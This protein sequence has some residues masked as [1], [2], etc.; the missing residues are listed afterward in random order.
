MHRLMNSWLH[1]QHIFC[2]RTQLIKPSVQIGMYDAE[3]VFEILNFEDELTLNDFFEVRKQN[4]LNT[5]KNLRLRLS[6]G[7]WQFLCWLRDLGPLKLA[8]VCFD[9]IDLHSSGQQ[10]A[11]VLWGCLLSVRRFWKRRGLGLARLQCF[12]SSSL[13][14]LVYRH[15]CCLTLE[16]MKQMIRLQ[17]KRKCLFLKLLVRLCVCVC[18]CVSEWEWVLFHLLLLSG[19]YN[20]YEFEPPPCGGTEITHKDAPQP[21]G[22]VWMSNQPVTETCAWQ[23]T[24]HSQRTTIHAPGGIRTR[25]PRKRSAVATRLW[26]LGHW[27]RRESSS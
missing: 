25:N 5:L 23:H 10:L 26:P 18:V 3:N 11:K 2:R 4:A 1:M 15:L 8:S 14:S 21:V 24:H 20:R 7:P 9:D 19:I 22:L 12:I 16:V 6:R 13:P 17:I 27:D